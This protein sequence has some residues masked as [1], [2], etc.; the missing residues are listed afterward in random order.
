MTNLDNE[1]HGVFDNS[2]CDLAGWLVQNDTEVV[3]CG[4]QRRVH[5]PESQTYFREDAVS[6]IRSIRVVEHLGYT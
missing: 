3:L 5:Q 2:L 4:D 6:W 1:S